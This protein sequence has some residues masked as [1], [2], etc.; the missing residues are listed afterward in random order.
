MK[1]TATAEYL[2]WL[3]AYLSQSKGVTDK[4]TPFCCLD[5]LHT[6]RT[7]SG[8]RIG[9]VGKWALKLFFSHKK[10]TKNASYFTKN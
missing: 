7:F 1:S 8:T 4:V 10:K 2:P 5:I 3:F 9:S 6:A